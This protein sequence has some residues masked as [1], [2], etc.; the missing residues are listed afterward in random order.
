MVMMVICAEIVLKDI[1]MLIVTEYLS[2]FLNK[3]ILP[4]TEVYLSSAQR[5]RF[6]DWLIINGLS[7]KEDLLMGGF[8]VDKLLNLNSTT[9][10]IKIKQHHEQYNSFNTL[11]LYN[12]IG[13][14]IQK[15]SE[16]FPDGL[17]L[18][19]KGDK[20][21]TNIFTLKELSYA[22]SKAFPLE[23]LTG[24]FAAKEAVIKC[25]GTNANK[26]FK[27]TTLEILPDP[28]GKPIINDCIVSIS[29]SSEYAIAI[30]ISHKRNQ[31]KTLKSEINN[32]DQNKTQKSPNKIKNSLRFID[33]FMMLSIIFLFGI[34]ILE[35]FKINGF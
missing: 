26:P 21:L 2:K 19:P 9:E 35:W 6:Y 31:F 1:K 32:I 11:S 25:L 17:P 8:S 15:I 28:T 18:D 14:D 13:V 7:F 5:A 10:S 4:S 3:S 20:E 24:I 29:H 23:T 33:I 27:L 22:Q 34:E 30:A 12:S 16:L